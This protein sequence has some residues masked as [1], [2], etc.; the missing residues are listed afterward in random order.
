[1]LAGN[2]GGPER[3]QFT[4][5]G[6][7]VNLASRLCGQAQSSQTIISSETARQPGLKEAVNLQ[8]HL[9]IQ[10]KGRQQSVTPVEVVGFTSDHQQHIEKVVAQLFPT[11]ENG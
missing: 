1:M 6:D 2:M 10:V 11:G 5:V 9:P 7:T 8:E 4:V 3:M